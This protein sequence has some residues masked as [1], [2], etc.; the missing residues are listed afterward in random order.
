[1]FI[2]LICDR[3]ASGLHRCCTRQPRVLYF[4][5]QYL[6]WRKLLSFFMDDEI[7]CPSWTMEPT[8][9]KIFS[10]SYLF[11][12]RRTT[13]TTQ[14]NSNRYALRWGRHVARSSPTLPCDSRASK[15]RSAKWRRLSTLRS[16]TPQREVT[17]LSIIWSRFTRSRRSNATH[18]PRAWSR[19]SRRCETLWILRVRNPTKIRKRYVPS[20]S[21]SLLRL[22]HYQLKYMQHVF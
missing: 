10:F 15:V 12:C 4:W 9:G 3:R 17:L 22:L 19:S 13:R 2:A 14:S 18:C 11:S 6:T 16:L 8:P 1:M 7:T 20:T 5:Q 21:I